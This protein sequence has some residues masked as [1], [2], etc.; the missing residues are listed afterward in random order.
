MFEIVKVIGDVKKFKKLMAFL[1]IML[2]HPN[3]MKPMRYLF[4][5]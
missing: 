4:M 5:N 2:K 1:K 3:S